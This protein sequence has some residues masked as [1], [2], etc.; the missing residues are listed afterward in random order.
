VDE[1]KIGLKLC[2]HKHAPAI[3]LAN[4]GDEKKIKKKK[5]IYIHI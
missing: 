3:S 1:R 5:Y 2:P 4:I